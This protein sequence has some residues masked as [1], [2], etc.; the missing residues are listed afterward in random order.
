[1]A[2]EGV[3]RPWYEGN[4]E[5]AKEIGQDLHQHY[6]TLRLDVRNGEAEVRGT[7]PILDE[8]GTELDRWEVSIILPPGYPN[9]LPVVRETGRR[10]PADLDNHVLRNDG[11]ACVLLPET[12]YKWF[13][14]GA[15]LRT[16][17]DGPMRAFFAN[18]S[19]RA[20]GGEW[21]HGEWDHGAL[22]AIQFYKELLGSDEDIVGWRGV[23]AMGLGLRDEQPCPC[24]RKRP[25]RQCHAILLDVRDNLGERIAQGRLGGALKEKFE[26]KDDDAAVAFLRAL[27]RDVKGHHPC[28]CGSGAR[29]RD[30]HPE[31]RELNGAMPEAFREKRSRPRRG[32]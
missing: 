28:P 3:V 19:Y 11:T 17:L 12:R 29:V 8:D 27:R 30:C 2:S 13:P 20:R 31:L 7:F 15:P 6:P 22:A 18:Q 26:I 4:P 23:M 25:I 9:D 5:L 16:F 1:M 24:G 32:R 10:I 14:R 21:V